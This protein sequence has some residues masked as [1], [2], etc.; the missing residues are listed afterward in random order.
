[1]KLGLGTAQF[2]MDY[3]VSNVIGKVPIHEV[4]K[5]LGLARQHGVSILDTA[6]AYGESEKILGNVLTSGSSFSIVT[7]TPAFE[8]EV[9][10]KRDVAKLSNAFVLSLKKLQQVSIYGLLAHT[11]DDLLKHGGGLLWDE[12]K[13]LKAQGLVEKI[14]VSIYTAV[15]IDNI[16]DK[17]SIDFIQLPINIFDQR[18]LLSGYLEKLKKRN[19]EVHARSAFLQGILLTK[20]EDLPSYFKPFCNH[21]QRYYEF[22]YKHNWSPVQAALGFVLGID[23]IDTVLL[24]VDS[25]KQLREIMNAAKPLDF[26]LFQQFAVD[27]ELLLN[28]SKWKL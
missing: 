26:T 1:M 11:V 2:G 4:Q 9:I 27:D 20:L 23:A 17:Y 18:L 12:M 16:L 8:S 15:Q 25:E 22:I 3:G 7:K 14:G 19:I 28:P 5:I 21:L 10:T 24:G 13:N 6:F